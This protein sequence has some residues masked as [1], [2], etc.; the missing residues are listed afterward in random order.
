MKFNSSKSKEEEC[1]VIE[2]DKKIA[3]INFKNDELREIV[4]KM[5][6]KVVNAERE[7]DIYEK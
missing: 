5:E 7:K 6:N 2:S 1:K 4:K 3:N